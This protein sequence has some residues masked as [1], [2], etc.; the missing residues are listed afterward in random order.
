MPLIF[1]KIPEIVLRATDMGAV[2][3]DLIELNTLPTVLDKPLTDNFDLIELT[4]PD[5]MLLAL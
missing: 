3:F 1:D 2:I 5:S 4:I